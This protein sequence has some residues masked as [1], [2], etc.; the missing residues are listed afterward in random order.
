MPPPIIG[1]SGGVFG[2]FVGETIGWIGGEY[3]V[4]SKR[5]NEILLGLKGPRRRTP[6]C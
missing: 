1:R 2:V 3:I 4:E 6:H 5:A